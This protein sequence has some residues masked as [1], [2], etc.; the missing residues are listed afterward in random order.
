MDVLNGKVS[1][2]ASEITRIVLMTRP[3]GKDNNKQEENHEHYCD[4][5]CRI[6][7]KQFY[8]LRDEAHPEDRI[9]CLD[10]LT[11]AGN[12]STLA[13]GDGQAEFSFRQARYL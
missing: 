4:R 12:L 2:R 10:K 7:R 11:Y 5:R 8:F 9:I 13:A 6:Y 3:L 1:G